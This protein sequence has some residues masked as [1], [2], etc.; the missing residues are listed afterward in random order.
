MNDKLTKT[1]QLNKIQSAALKKRLFLIVCASL[2]IIALFKTITYLGSTFGGS[3]GLSVIIILLMMM[4][5]ISIIFAEEITTL[6]LAPPRKVLL[7]LDAYEPMEPSNKQALFLSY[8][9]KG[10]SDEP[11]EAFLRAEHAAITPPV[12]NKPKTKFQEL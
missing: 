9:E 1:A 5:G 3:S 10:F 8:A 11:L 12:Q 2:L 6:F 4:G 7:L